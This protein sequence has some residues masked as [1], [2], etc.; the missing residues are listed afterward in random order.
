MND[1]P[2]DGS[3]L[4]LKKEII[5]LSRELLSRMEELHTLRDKIESLEKG[6]TLSYHYIKNDPKKF[7]F[8]TGISEH[9]FKWILSIVKTSVKQVLNTLSIEDHLLVVLIKFKLG[10]FNKDISFRFKIIE[11][12]VSR[13]YRQWLPIL[14]SSLKFLIIWPEKSAVKKHL[15]KCFRKYQACRCIIDCTE[16]FIERPFN[17]NARAQTWSNYKNTT[18]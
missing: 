16:T 9:V 4:E 3:E 1:K 12:M 5:A 2:D 6:W 11:V 15:P 8:Y 14:A 7:S 18:Q 10:L 17:L 13:I